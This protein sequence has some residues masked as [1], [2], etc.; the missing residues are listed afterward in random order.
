MPICS[1]L[2]GQ[3]HQDTKSLPLRRNLI[4]D[5]YTA[6]TE[7]LTTYRH[8]LL[9]QFIIVNVNVLRFT[10]SF[11]VRQSTTFAFVKTLAIAS[12]FKHY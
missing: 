4:V 11:V 2:E 1:I 5:R 8:N 12:G 3:E 10:K 6:L 9:M 7:V